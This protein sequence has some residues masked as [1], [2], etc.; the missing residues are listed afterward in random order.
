MG[1][2]PRRVRVRL[3]PGLTLTSAVVLPADTEIVIGVYPF[4]SGAATQPGYD[5]VSLSA[6]LLRRT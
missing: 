1:P 6:T 2:D 5:L 4:S 3:L